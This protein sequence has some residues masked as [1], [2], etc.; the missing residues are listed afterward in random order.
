MEEGKLKAAILI[1]SDTAARDPST[2]KTGEILSE[3][4]SSQGG[5]QWTTPERH[6]VPDDVLAVQRIVTQWCDGDHHVNLILTTGGTGFATKDHT[7]EA[8]APLLH[9]HAPGLV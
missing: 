4:F 3:A 1:I 8:I 2:D 9:R 7:P 6:V 5:N